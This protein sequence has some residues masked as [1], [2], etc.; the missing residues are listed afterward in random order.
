MTTVSVITPSLPSRTARLAQAMLSVRG[1]TLKPIEHL[2]AVD[3][4]RVGTGAVKTRLAMAARGEWLATLEDDDLLLPD[5]LATL[6][7][8]TRIVDNL[9]VVYSYCRVDGSNHLNGHIN[10]TFSRERLRKG[11]YIPST[12]LVRREL[13]A[14]LQGWR[15]SADCENGWEDWD[16]WLRALD[17]DARFGCV[18]AVTWI[19]RLHPGSKTFQGEQGAH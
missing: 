15:D 9:D 12:V 11:N 3:H 16:F 8:A 6:V 18:P 7:G 2:I 19:Y 17:V 14:E 1:Q 10:H 5:H 4:E 13:V